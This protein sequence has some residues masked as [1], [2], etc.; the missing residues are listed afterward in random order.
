MPL[1]RL[2]KERFDPDLALTNRLLVCL[3]L[4]VAS[5]PLEIVDVERA[6]DLAA[7]VAGGA[8]GFDRTSVADGRLTT[9]RHHAFGAFGRIATEDLS[10]RATVFIP[11]WVEDKVVLPV[12]VGAVG[13]VGQGD[14]GADAS[15]LD[16]DGVLR[17]TVLGA[18]VTSAA[19][20]MRRFPPSTT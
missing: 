13:E 4:V 14:V 6:L 8:L 2:G 19:R 7:V 17:R 16:G 5:H 3:G 10:L 15:V 18:G 11:L 1:L 20:M 12:E 9:I